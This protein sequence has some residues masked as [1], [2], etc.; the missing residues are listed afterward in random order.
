MVLRVEQSKITMD[1]VRQNQISKIALERLLPSVVDAI[2]DTP[3]V[4][5]SRFA[6]A[7]HVDGRI[8]A[9]LDPSGEEMYNF[10]M[11]EARTHL[12][13]AQSQLVEYH[14]MCEEAR[15]AV[16]QERAARE[17]VESVAA[18][19]AREGAV[20]VPRS[21]SYSSRQRS[22]AAAP[23]PAC[24]SNSWW[25]RS[26]LLSHGTGM[27]TPPSSGPRRRSS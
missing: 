19:A 9:K 21:V 14:A 17:H 2:G 26:S 20:A 24:C 25:V 6:A 5:L 12:D 18:N 27:L 13:A 1:G 3:L 16:L 22:T 8:L 11:Q 10:R 4:E 15:T 23:Q 7:S